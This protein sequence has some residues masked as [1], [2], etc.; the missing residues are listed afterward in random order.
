MDNYISETDRL[1]IRNWIDQDIPLFAAMNAD[2][3][4]ME[5]FHKRLTEIE[6]LDMVNRIKKHI[7]EK[8]YGLWAIELKEQKQFIGFTGLNYTDFESDF[9]PCVEIGWRL[10][11]PYWNKGYATEAAIRCLELAFGRFALDEVVSFTS[12]YN[13][14][15]ENVMRKIGMTMIKEFNHPKLDESDSLIR[16]VLYKMTK[17]EFED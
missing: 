12:I 11:K 10:N 17:E 1:I 14:R 13:R 3:D 2:A 6:S 16:H 9:T 4:V 7:D 15:S 8:G 5:Y